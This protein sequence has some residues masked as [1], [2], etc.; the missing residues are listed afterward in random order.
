M[1]GITL[2]GQLPVVEYQNN[3]SWRLWT[4]YNDDYSTGAYLELGTSG[5]IKRVLVYNK[6]VTKTEIIKPV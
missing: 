5:E 1:T 2:A 4:S 3:G 6:K